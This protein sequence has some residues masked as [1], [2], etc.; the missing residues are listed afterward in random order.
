ML[1]DPQARLPPRTVKAPNGPVAREENLYRDSMAFEAI[2][3]PY[4]IPLGL[5]NQRLLRPRRRFQ[6]EAEA[7]GPSETSE[8]PENNFF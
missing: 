6:A 7:N 2:P 4:D 1:P 3:A 8:T 5:V